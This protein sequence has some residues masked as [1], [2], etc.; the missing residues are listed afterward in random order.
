MRLGG[1]RTLAEQFRR[2]LAR[3]ATFAAPEPVPCLLWV[4]STL[5]VSLDACPGTAIAG[6]HESR[7]LKE[8][9]R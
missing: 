3:D 2:I 8:M 5:A 9:P 7:P 1:R 6:M 4:Y